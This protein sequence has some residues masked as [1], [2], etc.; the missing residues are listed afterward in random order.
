MEGGGLLPIG[1]PFLQKN[2]NFQSIQGGHE[3]PTS[4]HYFS[5]L[6]ADQTAKQSNLIQ[7]RKV[8][9]PILEGVN[10]IEVNTAKPTTNE[11][12]PDA[13]NRGETSSNNAMLVPDQAANKDRLKDEINGFKHS[14]Y[15]EGGSNP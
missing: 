9:A 1:S 14:F 7:I 2:T 5:N 15:N 13:L 4:N 10:R 3:N 6:S 11:N 8:S 12:D